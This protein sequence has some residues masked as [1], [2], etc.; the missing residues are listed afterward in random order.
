[1]NYGIKEDIL[2]FVCGNGAAVNE[3]LYNF[4]GKSL[5]EN[6]HLGDKQGCA[7]VNNKIKI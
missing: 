2:G 1:L 4:G 7:K 6:I 3:Y 5:M